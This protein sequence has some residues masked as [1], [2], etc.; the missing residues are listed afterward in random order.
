MNCG[1]AMLSQ[2]GE[3]LQLTEKADKFHK[4]Q[5]QMYHYAALGKITFL[6]IK[7]GIKFQSTLKGKKVLDLCSGRGGGAAFLSRYFEA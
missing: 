2:S 1:Y 4:F 6:I 3:T 7:I 5:Y